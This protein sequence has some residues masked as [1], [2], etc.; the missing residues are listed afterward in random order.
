[1]KSFLTLLFL[2]TSIAAFSQFNHDPYRDADAGNFFLRNGKVFFQRTYNSPLSFEELETKLRSY[3]TPAG[4]FQINKTGKNIMNGV[5]VNFHL[6]WNYTELKSRKI[7]DY[8]KYPANATYEIE[9][10]GNAYQVR[11]N[12]IWFSN[13]KGTKNQKHLT[14]ENMVVDKNGILFTKKKRDLLALKMI[15]ENFQEI[16]K[17]IGS[18][19]DTRF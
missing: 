6:N 19:K 3:N 14:I 17:M 15:D 1:M 11:V 5:L 13:P 18:T 10:N 8:L 12:N 4:G 7:S 9:K 16:F 2:V